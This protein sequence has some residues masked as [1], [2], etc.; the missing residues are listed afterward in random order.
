MIIYLKF[1]KL[2]NSINLVTYTQQV[3]YVIS[4]QSIKII[5]LK[6]D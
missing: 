5:Q 6:V 4:K 2:K 1:V 3:Y